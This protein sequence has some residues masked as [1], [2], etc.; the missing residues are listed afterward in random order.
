M[1]LSFLAIALVFCTLDAQAQPTPADLT[2]MVVAS[3]AAPAAA[4]YFVAAAR[5]A[6]TPDL[7]TSLLL[8]LAD[9]ESNFDS[10]ATSRLVGGK[11]Q[12]GP[13]R[14]LTPP[15]GATGNYFCGVTQA[16]APTWKRCLEL[17]DPQVAFAVG[18]AELTTWLRRGG[19]VQRAL[20]GHGC[21][22]AGMK[23]ACRNYAARVLRRAR[24]FAGSKP[25]S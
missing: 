24:Y 19:T 18:A 1:K 6:A 21:G 4:P 5:A 11:R 22:N 16:I 10:T 9:I 25:T 14:R 12:T 3:G 20:Q 8:G 17:R 15:P 23:G 2:A 7:P 13:W